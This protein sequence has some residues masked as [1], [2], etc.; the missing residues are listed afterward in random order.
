MSLKNVTVLGATGTLGSFILSSLLA[1]EPPFTITALVR[2]FSNH[3]FPDKVTKKALPENPS[4]ADLKPFLQGQDA[5]ICILPGSNVDLQK[6]FAEAAVSTG[7][8]LFI[9]ADFGS[10]DSSDSEVLLRLKLYRQKAEVRKYLEDLVAKNPKSAFSWTSLVCGHFL[11]H[12]LET[13]L[14]GFNIK[15]R[16][17]MLYDRGGTSKFSASTRRR[18]GEAVVK[19][20]QAEGEV[21]EWL[22]NRLIYVQSLAVSQEE[23][24]KELN[25]TFAGDIDDWEL[26]GEESDKAIDNL[27]EEVDKTGD[28]GK[29]EELVAVMGMAYSDWRWHDDFANDRLVKDPSIEEHNS[30]T[31]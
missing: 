5:F 13:E 21:R 24:L 20:L 29:T 14:L 11:D 3:K 9:P 10:C 19:V 26:D 15:K 27:V 7:V 6:A 16:T 17:G 23:I 12:G 28:A 31:H 1:A 30:E 22:R 18:I 2:P 25:R 8:K 4:L